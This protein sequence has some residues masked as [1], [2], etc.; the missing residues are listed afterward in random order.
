MYGQRMQRRWAF[1][2]LVLL[3]WLAACTPDKGFKTRDISRADYG[4]RWPLT[5]DAAVLACELGGIPTVTVD[6]RSYSL[7]SANKE[8]V[9]SVF[10]LERILAND[11]EG[12]K[13]DETVLLRHALALC[14]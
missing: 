12:G 1:L 9:P 14:E 7:E 3:T 5:V 10:R 4:D 13:K 8:K 6:G 11:S 2:F